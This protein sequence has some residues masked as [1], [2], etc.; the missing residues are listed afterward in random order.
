MLYKN[1]NINLEQRRWHR[2]IFQIKEQSKTPEEKLSDMELGN[3]P[4]KEF[5]VMVIKMIKELD[6][7]NEKLEE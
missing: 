2:N 5:M 6:A 3:L 7:H 4:R 1:T